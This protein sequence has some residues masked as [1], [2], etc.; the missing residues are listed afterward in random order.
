MNS[1]AW[2]SIYLPVFVLL[3]V[4]L[5][6]QRR[7]QESLVLKIKKRRGVRPVANEIIKKYLGENCKISTGSLGT[8]VIGK[9]I[10]VNE[11]WIEVETKKGAE[12]VNADFIQSIKVITR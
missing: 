2:I 3:F 4:I 5:P 9:I 10:E 6:Q 11:N 8:T 7:V 12:L 1:A